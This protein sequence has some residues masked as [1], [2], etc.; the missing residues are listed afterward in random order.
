MV[1][2]PATIRL[3]PRLYKEVQK[4]ADKAGLTFSSVVQLLLNA[5]IEGTVQIGVSQYPRRYLD[6]LVREADDLRR[7]HREGKVKGYASAKELFDAI[8]DR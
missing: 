3:D 4:E 2:Q 7:R 1:K 5:Y 8:L 6:T